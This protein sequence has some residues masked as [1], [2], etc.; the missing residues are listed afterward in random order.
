MIKAD[1]A[2]TMTY[3]KEQSQ[4]FQQ[5]LHLLMSAPTHQDLVGWQIFA[6]GF[7]SSKRRPLQVQRAGTRALQETGQGF[8]RGKKGEG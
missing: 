1:L 6:Y 3:L 8:E 2:L 4:C 5:V 7:S